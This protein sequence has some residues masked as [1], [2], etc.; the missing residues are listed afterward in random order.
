MND[1]VWRTDGMIV[2]REQ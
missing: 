1:L 2:T